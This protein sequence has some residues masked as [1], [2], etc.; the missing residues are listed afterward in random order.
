MVRVRRHEVVPGVQRRELGSRP[1]RERAVSVGRPLQRGIVMHHDN[2]VARQVHIELDTVGAER[3]TVIECKDCVL[4]AKRRPAAVREHLRSGQK[5][6]IKLNTDRCHL[7][8]ADGRTLCTTEWGHL[9]YLDLTP[10]GV[11]VAS[12][13]FPFAAPESWTPPVLS[14]GL[15]YLSQNTPD[16]PHGKPPRLLCYDLRGGG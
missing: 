3:E 11:K 6:T 13:L 9:L 7:L 12:R 10:A 4:G 14:R 2:A 5:R 16:N 15:L 8:Y 1:R